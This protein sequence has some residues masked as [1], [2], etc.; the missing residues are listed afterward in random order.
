MSR[1]KR[2]DSK[3]D[4]EAEKKEKERERK[5]TTRKGRTRSRAVMCTSPEQT[6]SSSST[7]NTPWTAS[8]PAAFRFIAF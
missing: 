8:A 4:E 6:I 1:L 7:S 5:R 2:L 3:E